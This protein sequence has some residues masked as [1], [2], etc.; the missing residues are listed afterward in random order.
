MATIST[1]Q[2]HSFPTTNVPNSAVSV[3]LADV[4]ADLGG[5][6][7]HR[8]LTVCGLN[9]SLEDLA[10]THRAGKACEFVD[11]LLVE[12]AMGFRESLLAAALVEI[13]VAFVRL[14]KLGFV[15]GPDGFIRLF[16]DVIRGPDVAFISWARLPGGK[17]PEEAYPA[18]V[19]DLVIEV[20]SEGNTRAE[21]ARKR[22]EYFYAGVRL[23]WMVDPL[24]RSVAVFTSVHQFTVLHEENHLNGG[25]VLP[26]LAIS[27]SELFSIFDSEPPEVHK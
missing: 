5:I 10:E 13:L 20:I 4:L 11:G 25:D 21:M 6:S 2:P 23:V 27:L 14:K 9:A 19:P 22:R 12:K 3:S 8:L 16:P 24:Q 17:L 26:G 18:I 7:A 1:P 15:S